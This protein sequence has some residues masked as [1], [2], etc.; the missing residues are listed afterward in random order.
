MSGSTAV[1]G[2]FGTNSDTG[3]TYL[4]V[5]G[6][7]GWPTDPTT[8]LPD[9]EATA[10]DYF[11]YSVAVSGKTAIASANWG[12]DG[13]V[14]IYAK[15]ASGWPTKP[16]AGMTDPSKAAEYFGYSVAVSGKTGVVGAWGTRRVAG[17]A[18]IYKA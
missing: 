7:S 13:P 1:V 12:A 14:F 11:G 2:A 9:P 16:T 6:S 15:G 10:N 3:A 4:Y 18:Y 5:K 17:A 8:A